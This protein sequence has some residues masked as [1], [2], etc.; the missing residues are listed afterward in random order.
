MDTGCKK[1]IVELNHVPGQV[2]SKKSESIGISLPKVS[3][4]G[5]SNVSYYQGVNLKEKNFEVYLL[6]QE[7]LRNISNDGRSTMLQID[8]ID[9]ESCNVIQDS[10][11][12]GS[13]PNVRLVKK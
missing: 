9:F 3:P 7:K 10:T 8:S 1:E 6:A 4:D 2:I 12:T 11:E 5:R 13:V